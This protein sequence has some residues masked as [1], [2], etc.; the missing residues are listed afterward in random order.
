[1]EKPT[2]EPKDFE[3]AFVMTCGMGKGDVLYSAIF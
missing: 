3:T 1:M 2:L